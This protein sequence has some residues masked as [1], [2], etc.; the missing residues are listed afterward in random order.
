MRLNTRQTAFQTLRL[1]LKFEFLRAQPLSSI[2]ESG[3]SVGEISHP[4]RGKHYLL[5]TATDGSIQE[6]R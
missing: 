1:R 4:L 2:E 3:M 5:A 6:T